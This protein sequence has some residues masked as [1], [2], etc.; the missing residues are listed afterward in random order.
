LLLPSA[1]RFGAPSFDVSIA[2]PGVERA[3]RIA[4]PGV[5]RAARSMIF[6]PRAV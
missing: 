5:E 6:S 2:A 3:A 4:A 1:C